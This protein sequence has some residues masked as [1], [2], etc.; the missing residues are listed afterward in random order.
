MC[1]ADGSL[2]PCNIN[3][4]KYFKLEKRG[5]KEREEISE[6][7]TNGWRKGRSTR[8]E[9]CVVYTHHTDIPVVE[10]QSMERGTKRMKMLINTCYMSPNATGIFL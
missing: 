3:S 9:M 2:W 4:D 8:M 1:T 5:K 6:Q 10:L 7:R